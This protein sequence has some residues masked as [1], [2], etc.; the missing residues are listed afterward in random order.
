[1]EVHHHSHTSRKKWTHYFWEFLML[2]LAVLAGFL[3]ENQRE[4]Y[5][6][7]L[8]E[9]QYMKL[10]VAD[11]QA[12]TA[13]MHNTIKEIEL[14]SSSIDS[15]LLLLTGHLVNDEVVSK[16]YRFTYPGLNN[17]TF[18][19]ND[20]T[21]TQLKNSGNMRIIRNQKVNDS[22]IH[23][24]N[25]IENVTQASARHMAYRTM[26]RE[27]ETRIYNVAGLYL[28]NNRKIDVDSSNIELISNS[29]LLAKEYANIIASSGIMLGSLRNLLNRQY[30]YA[31][32]LITLIKEEYH[33]K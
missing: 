20:R 29:L 32:D 25:H 10:M 13:M 27:M 23:Y 18:A 21:I 4:H 2:F 1:M 22:I 31:I 17:L 8:R 15:M 24:W 9:K 3:A 19:F 11:L 12:D 26:G 16:S 6:E 14:R 33:L 7:H 30:K 28:K 5:V